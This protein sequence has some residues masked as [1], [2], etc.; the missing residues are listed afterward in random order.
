MDNEINALR[1]DIKQI[2]KIQTLLLE[3][4]NKSTDQNLKTNTELNT[5]IQL[6]CS[7]FGV[8]KSISIESIQYLISLGFNITQIAKL[9]NVTRP[10]VYN[11]LNKE[12]GGGKNE[13]D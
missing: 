10:T 9:L 1:E 12:N 2:K 8:N 5:V 13:N 7:Y 4:Y 6:I 3:L 11:I